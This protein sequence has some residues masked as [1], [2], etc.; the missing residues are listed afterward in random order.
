[1]AIAKYL[2]YPDL[3][4]AGVVTNRV[5]LGRMIKSQGFPAGRLLGFNTRA[6]TET[7]IR[8]W[9]DSRPVERAP[10]TIPREQR[11]G[12]HNK[13]KAAAAKT[14]KAQAKRSTPKRRAR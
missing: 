14:A 10:D 5:T 11:F 9:L 8:E 12:V 1:M 4:E 2:R 3:V 6:W 7:E 13:A